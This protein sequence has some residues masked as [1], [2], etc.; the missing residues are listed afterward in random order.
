MLPPDELRFAIDI[1]SRS[2]KVLRWL[3]RA[4]D[5]GEIPIPRVISSR[6][7]DDVTAATM[8]WIE[9]FHMSFPQEMRPSPDKLREF[10]AFFGTYLTS[11]FDLINHPG[12]VL[13]SEF[14]GTCFCPI[15]ARLVAGSHLKAKK[16]TSSDKRR[17]ILLTLDR[18]VELAHEHD[19]TIKTSDA[20]A[21]TANPEHRIAAAYSTYGYWLI[22]RTKGMTD[23][24]SILA[25][26]RQI[27]WTDAG[28]PRKDFKLQYEDFAESESILLTSMRELAANNVA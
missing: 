19:L 23:G 21:L 22:R 10:A 4:I 13:R 9:P 24:S 2:Y 15:C 26:W 27:A 25:L 5:L 7:V 6:H 11:S 17:S 18:L 12:V 20:E 8:D 3:G 16:L 1:H 14:G 28:S